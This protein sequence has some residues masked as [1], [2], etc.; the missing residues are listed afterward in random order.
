[1]GPRLYVAASFSGPS[2]VDLTT[3]QVIAT[4]PGGGSPNEKCLVLSPDGQRL[5]AASYVGV[6]I[7]D[8]ATNQVTA[9]VPVSGQ[10][11]LILS[12]DGQRLSVV[13]NV[14][15][16]SDSSHGLLSVVDTHS[17]QVVA[18]AK[19]MGQAGLWYAAISPN[20]RWLY[21]A[22]GE[23]G[24]VSVFDTTANQVVATIQPVGRPPL[25]PPPAGTPGGGTVPPPG[26]PPGVPPPPLPA[27]PKPGV[28]A[29]AVSPDGQRLYVAFRDQTVAVIDTVQNRISDTVD[30]YPFGH[31][32]GLDRDVGDAVLSP[33]GKRLYVTDRRGSHLE[34][35]DTSSNRPTAVLDLSQGPA[36]G[37]NGDGTS[38]AVRP[39]GQR[40]YVLPR[41]G[42][43]SVAVVDTAS[44]QVTH[45]PV[46][47]YPFAL[48]LSAAGDRLC[49]SC[50]RTGY[51]ENAPNGAVSIIDTAANRVVAIVEVGKLPTCM[52][53]KP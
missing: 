10:L 20:G 21:V 2:V 35:I 45:I 38:M 44:F 3:N 6:A 16:N 28:A 42:G 36:P 40:V 41:L 53:V 12:P 8:T 1:V 50:W 15:D 51:P 39:D 19:L 27:E 13:S 33:D 5:F 32:F 47:P 22:S 17:N 49:V 9:T 29:L 30:L 24:V 23:D 34:V 37:E 11:Q 14:W 25:P 7:I 43:P 46:E 48:A 4:L 18:A 31:P 52:A 26:T